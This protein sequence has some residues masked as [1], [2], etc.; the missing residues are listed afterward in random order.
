MKIVCL[1]FKPLQNYKKA[2]H[3]SGS[4]SSRFPGM[5]TSIFSVMSKL[6]QENK[7]INLSQGFPDFDCSTELTDLVNRAMKDG[8]NQ[9]APMP[10]LPA[11]RETIA[12]KTEKLYGAAYHPESEVTVTAGAT[13]AIFTALMCLIQPGDEAIIIEPAYDCYAPAV[14]LAG[15]RVIPVELSFPDYRIDWEGVKNKISPATKVIIVNSP[16]NPGCTIFTESDMQALIRITAN[17]GITIL[18]DEVYEHI[19][20]DNKKHL[21]V[22]AFPE[23]RERAFVVSSFGKSFH[24]T[25]WKVAYILAPEKL[26]AEFRKIHQYNVFSVNTPMQVAINAFLKNPAHYLELGNF[27]Q[28]KRDF[29]LESMK[30]TPFTA[31][32]CQGTYF[33]LMGFEKISSLSDYDFAVW[34]TKNAGVACVPLSPFY[35]AGTDHKVVR[36]CFAKKNE[37]MEEAGKRLALF[38]N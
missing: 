37:T 35:S 6:A 2:M 4:I 10:G 8:H 1:L 30:S 11:L 27:Y 38:F 34:L 22:A 13:Q 17:T 15:G 14:T 20:F 18:S 26:M 32:P 25:G 9:Y 29:F 3:F 33:Q 36:F 19:V 28:Q 23:L 12:E 5:S 31:L 16:N 24:V 7:A 21:S